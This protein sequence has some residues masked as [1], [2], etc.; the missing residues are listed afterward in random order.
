MC[1]DIHDGREHK[2]SVQGPDTEAHDQSSP[3]HHIR[4]ATHGRSIQRV[5][6]ADSQRCAERSHVRHRAVSEMCHFP[7]HS[8]Q[9]NWVLF[10]HLVGE[11]QQVLGHSVARSVNNRGGWRR[12]ELVATF[13]R[14]PPRVTR[15][16][17]PRQHKRSWC[18]MPGRSCSLQ[19]PQTP[20]PRSL[21]RIPIR[22]G[23]TC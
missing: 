17:R 4:L 8:L 18:W 1:A 9:Q 6:K 11:R 3:D 21:Y 14:L 7:F 5:P 22:A 15:W 2:S 16:P 19:P 10:D 13:R 20:L 12:A 23:A